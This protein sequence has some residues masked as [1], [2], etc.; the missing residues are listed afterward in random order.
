MAVTEIREVHEANWL[1]RM[2]SACSGALKG[3]ALV[4]GAGVLIFFNEGRAVKTARSLDEGAGAVVSVPSDK[5]DP[6]NEGKL[7]HVSGRADT[8]DELSDPVFGISTVSLRLN[9]KVE[10]YQ[11]VE[12]EETHRE[13]QGDKTIE[14]TTYTYAK[15][16][17]SKP[18][19]SQGFKE[20]G[21]SNPAAAMPF[22]DEEKFAK[23]ATLGAFRLSEVNL[24]RM[25]GFKAL[26]FAPDFKLPEALKGASLVNGV[27]YL[28]TSTTAP[29]SASPTVSAGGT[30]PLMAAAKAAAGAVTNAVN[31]ALSNPA[32]NPQ[33]GDLRVTFTVVEPH[34]ISLCFKQRGDTFVPWTSSNGRAIELQEDGLVDAAA[35][36]ASAKSANSTLTWILRFVGFMLMFGGFK[37]VFAPFVTLVDVIPLLNGIVSIGLKLVAFLLATAGS[38]LTAGVA[39]IFYRPVLGIT[40]VA[41]AVACVV[42]LL[43]MK[44]GK[45][46]PAK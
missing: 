7:V 17:C 18:V 10:I 24:K 34:D 39:W 40:L 35:M 5:V 23:N 15:Q 11:W 33:L 41:I 44:R 19:D 30:S 28:P 2:G 9:R 8:K 12:K 37:M 36:F 22:S 20:A 31:G 46:A 4:V 32:A 3:L 25:H 27:I 1:E 13:K 42:L 26:P 16:W 21:H 45:A 38:L 43:V 6:A 29:T 14:K